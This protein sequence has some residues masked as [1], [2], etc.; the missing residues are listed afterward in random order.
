MFVEFIEIASNMLL[1][2]ETRKFIAPE[3][4]FYCWQHIAAHGDQT[5]V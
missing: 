4:N 2:R 5:V 3:T 1:D